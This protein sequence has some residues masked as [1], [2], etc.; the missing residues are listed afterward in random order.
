MPKSKQG[1]TAFGHVHRSRRRELA[2]SEIS[3]INSLPSRCTCCSRL[4]ADRALFEEFLHWLPVCFGPSARMTVES[5]RRYADLREAKLRATIQF[6]E[7]K[8]DD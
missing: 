4:V 6:A 7:V 8:R 2:S 1:A 3:L 5:V